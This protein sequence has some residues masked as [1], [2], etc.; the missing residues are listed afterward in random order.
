[1]SNRERAF[2]PSPRFYGREERFNRMNDPSPRGAGRVRPH[3]PKFAVAVRLDVVDIRRRRN[4]ENGNPRRAAAPAILLRSGADSRTGTT[5][6]PRITLRCLDRHHTRYFAAWLSHS[7][8]MF[9]EN[10]VRGSSDRDLKTAIS[11]PTPTGCSFSAHTHWLQEYLPGATNP[12]R[13]PGRRHSAS[14][15]GESTP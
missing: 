2:A 1:M 14:P 15:G 4:P 6:P 3:R 13:E 10:L 9:R 12:C 11:V 5:A 7:P 8:K